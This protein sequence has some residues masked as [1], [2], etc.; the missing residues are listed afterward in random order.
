MQIAA[1]GSTFL[2]LPF[3]YTHSYRTLA[4]R[5]VKWPPAAALRQTSPPRRPAQPR[6]VWRL[7]TLS[8]CIATMPGCLLG[9]TILRS[10]T[11]LLLHPDLRR[12]SS[13]KA[14]DYVHTLVCQ[15]A[16]ETKTQF[17]AH[18][19]GRVLTVAD[20][21]LR[22]DCGLCVGGERAVGSRRARAFVS[23]RLDSAATRTYRYARISGEPNGPRRC[24]QEAADPAEAR[25]ACISIGRRR[26]AWRLLVAEAPR[27]VVFIFRRTRRLARSLHHRYAAGL[28]RGDFQVKC[29]S[30]AESEGSFF[31]RRNDTFTR[32][33]EVSPIARPEVS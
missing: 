18:L 16:G 33:L 13:T 29:S 10:T 8:S 15:L 21:V 3:T 6:V 12:P 26:N 31:L 19:V 17:R 7:S 24:G 5:G 28:C 23:A 9:T 1:V 27:A 2:A 30:A 22:C 32:N 20:M 4:R 25:S 11:R 14:I